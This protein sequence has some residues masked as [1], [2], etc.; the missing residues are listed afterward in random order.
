LYSGFIQHFCVG[1][2]L[3]LI[4]Q[5]QS[6][7]HRIWKL[8]CPS[9]LKFIFHKNKRPIQ[10]IFS[11]HRIITPCSYKN[12]HF[13]IQCVIVALLTSRH[14]RI[15]RNIPGVCCVASRV[16]V[17]K[18]GKQGRDMYILSLLLKYDKLIA[19]NRRI[20][21]ECIHTL[22]FVSL[23]LVSPNTSWTF[24]EVDDFWRKKNSMGHKWLNILLG[25]HIYICKPKK[26]L[27]LYISNDFDI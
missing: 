13:I 8:C 5:H 21:D 27:Y 4:M 18:R 10:G 1:Y 23:A 14:H 15:Q 19:R 20:I 6:N 26:L 12:K 2:V 25:D 17:P 24:H 3:R 9:L 16:S 11:F 22:N 7:L